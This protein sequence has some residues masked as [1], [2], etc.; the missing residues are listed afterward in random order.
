MSV[1]DFIKNSILESGVFDGVS[2][3]GA[4]LGLLTALI[5]GAVIYFVYRKFYTGSNDPIKSSVEQILKYNEYTKLYGSWESSAPIVVDSARKYK[6]NI[7]CF[8]TKHEIL[9]N[10]LI[11]RS[12]LYTT[13]EVSERV[14]YGMILDELKAAMDMANISSMECGAY[15]LNDID[16]PDGGGGIR[17]GEF[18]V[19]NTWQI[20]KLKPRMASAEEKLVAYESRISA[21]ER[22]I[23]NLKNS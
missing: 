20:Q 14:H 12:F 22:E 10:N 4:L 18:I 11:P 7:S 5:M 8:D 1:Q 21:L 6:K 19:L 9:F 23:E 15:C 16:D 13:G 2:L 17:Y 3:T